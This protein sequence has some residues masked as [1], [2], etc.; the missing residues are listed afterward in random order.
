MNRISFVALLVVLP[1]ISPAQKKIFTF[2]QIFKG[3]FPSVFKPLPEI[4]GWVDDEHYIEIRTADNGNESAFSVD[5]KT[6]K[7]TPY[8]HPDSE[9]MKTPDIADAQNITLS[10][11]GK[12][13]AYTRKNVAYFLKK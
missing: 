4:G 3:Q 2:D 7:T 5:V 8:I 12:Y 11:D 13:A 6:G 1:L 9:R 10:P